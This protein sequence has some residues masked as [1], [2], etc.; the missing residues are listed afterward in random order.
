MWSKIAI[1][2][3]VVFRL[4]RSVVLRSCRDYIDRF[5]AGT[6]QN[7]AWLVYVKGQTEAPFFLG[8]QGGGHW[9]RWA[10]PEC[11]KNKKDK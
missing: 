11:N 3:A 4:G 7:D 10:Q 2:F 6:A 5:P 8:Q 9:V 1:A